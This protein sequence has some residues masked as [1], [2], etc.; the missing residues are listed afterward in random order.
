M[1]KRNLLFVIVSFIILV[2]CEEETEKLSLEER[3][4]K[5]MEGSTLWN[6]TYGHRRIGQI[7]DELRLIKF[8]HG[9][10]REIKLFYGIWDEEEGLREARG[11]SIIWEEY[12]VDTKSRVVTFYGEEGVVLKV[13]VVSS[14]RIRIIKWNEYIE[15]SYPLLLKSKDE[16][17]RRNRERKRNIKL[18]SEKVWKFIAEYE[19]IKNIN[20]FVGWWKF[21]LKENGW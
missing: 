4:N 6:Q 9:S 2:G 1:Q 12:D 3:L 18:E 11:G 8:I 13:L 5:L 10:M 16:R 19:K 20:E 15:K 7:D 14:N 17:E 21:H